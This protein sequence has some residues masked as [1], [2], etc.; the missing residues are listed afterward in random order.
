MIN[1]WK[2]N[3]GHLVNIDL[4]SN[5]FCLHSI[6]HTISLC[7]CFFQYNTSHSSTRPMRNYRFDFS[8]YSG[9]LLFFC[10]RL[11][12]A[13]TTRPVSAM[14][15]LS[16]NQR[17]EHDHVGL[18]LIESIFN[19]FVL[20]RSIQKRKQF[21]W[22]ND[23]SNLFIIYKTFTIKSP[24]NCT[25]AIRFWETSKNKTFTCFVNSIV[26]LF[27]SSSQQTIF[28]QHCR[29]IAEQLQ[30]SRSVWDRKVTKK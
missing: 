28:N 2:E 20:N 9:L 26:F 24:N 17:F 10:F 11:V 6:R 13:A 30:R 4:I 8:L 25:V 5:C 29:K 18:L 7:C 21:E 16:E 15:N 3:E 27:L 14:S 23:T 19:I 22:L 12:L 1:R